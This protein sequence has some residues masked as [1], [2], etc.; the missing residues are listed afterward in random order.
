MKSDP[1]FFRE[2]LEALA[3]NFKAAATDLIG[4]AEKYGGTTE[5]RKMAEKA[6]RLQAYA[7]YALGTPPRFAWAVSDVEHQMTHD[8]MKQRALARGA[9]HYVQLNDE[10]LQPLTGRR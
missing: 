3:Y 2:D 7:E 6:A 8:D 9:R 5:G 10:T 1:T 4:N